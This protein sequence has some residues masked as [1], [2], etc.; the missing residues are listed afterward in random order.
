MLAESVQQQTRAGALRG[1]GQERPASR[2]I[3][4][5]HRLSLLRKQD[6]GNTFSYVLNVRCT[7][8]YRSWLTFSIRSLRICIHFIP[9]AVRFWRHK[10]SPLALPKCLRKMARLD[11]RGFLPS[12]ELKGKG[13]AYFW[14]HVVFVTIWDVFHEPCDSTEAVKM[15]QCCRKVQ[16]VPHRIWYLMT[17]STWTLER[18][19]SGGTAGNDDTSFKKSEA[20][21]LQN[22]F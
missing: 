12:R 2:F 15:S 4:S 6:E 14:L 22:C 17:P 1:L 11:A 13:S 21:P 7:P 16:T 20:I 10:D 3:V 9:A 19:A 18:G 5:S 8:L